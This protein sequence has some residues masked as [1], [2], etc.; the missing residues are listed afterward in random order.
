MSA[1]LA[2][3]SVGVRLGTGAE[4]GTF[5][6]CVGVAGGGARGQEPVLG[7]V[8]E[9]GVEQQGQRGPL[10]QDR[11]VGGRTGCGCVLFEDGS[12]SDGFSAG[13]QCAAQGA[14]IQE[15][16]VCLLASPWKGSLSPGGE[17]L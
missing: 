12:R 11:A 1:P 17:A 6:S 16:G 7:G 3:T 5:I 4:T 8:K 2:G 10:L 13:K 14:G 9:V 15:D